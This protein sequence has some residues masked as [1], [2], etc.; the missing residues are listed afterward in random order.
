MV[1]AT[2]DGPPTMTWAAAPRGANMPATLSPLMLEECTFAHTA[3]QGEVTPLCSVFQTDP[4]RTI[5]SSARPSQCRRP[6]TKLPERNNG[7]V[8]PLRD[9]FRDTADPRLLDR[10][11]P[12]RVRH[13]QADSVPAS[14]VDN[15]GHRHSRQLP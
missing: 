9:S 13:D 1:P 11:A 7:A 14:M 4:L 2:S 8:G 3:P 5:A 15:L 10:H 12:V 6:K